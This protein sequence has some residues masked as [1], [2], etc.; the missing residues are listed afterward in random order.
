M[1]ERDVSSR[2]EFTAWLSEKNTRITGRVADKWGWMKAAWTIPTIDGGT[3]KAR[4]YVRL[5]E[6]E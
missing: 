4:A 3:H 5:I 2:D 1:L 6:S